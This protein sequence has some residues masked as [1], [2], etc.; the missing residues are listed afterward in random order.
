MSFRCEIC[1]KS[2]G[3]GC[4]VSH[5]HRR[6]RHFFLP[7]LQ[8]ARVRIG[9]QVRTVRICTGCLKAGKVQKA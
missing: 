7:N 3:S 8:N 9:G 4:R 6:T 2:A 5:S 1:G